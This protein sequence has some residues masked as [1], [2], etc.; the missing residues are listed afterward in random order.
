MVGDR[1]GKGKVYKLP[2]GQE[3]FGLGMNLLVGGVGRDKVGKERV[4]SFKRLAKKE[5]F[6]GK[7]IFIEGTGTEIMQLAT[8]ASDIWVSMPRSTREACGTS[9]NRA[10]FNGHINIATKTGGAAEYIINGVNGWLY[11][12]FRGDGVFVW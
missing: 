6:R 9:D 8:Q 2:W 10:A 3:S 5:D 4:E 12:C 11:G 7:I 1:Q